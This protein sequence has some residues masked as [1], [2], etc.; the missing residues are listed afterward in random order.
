M[1]GLSWQHAR[2]FV[3]ST[4]ADLE[5]A[6]VQAHPFDSW[7]DRIRLWQLDAK[8]VA[9]AWLSPPAELDWHQRAEL[10]T[11]V[12]ERIIEEA[13]AW[14]EEAAR[15]A[16]EREGGRGPVSLTAWAMDAD[17]LLTT[18]LSREG[19]AADDAWALTHWY[20][21]LVD[22]PP[23]PGPRL[24][25]GYRLRHVRWPD[26]LAARVEVH[27]AA[28]APSKMTLEKYRRLAEMPH[29]SPDLDLVVEAPD[30][31]FAAFTLA[32]RDP[33]GGIGELEPVGT[34]P[35]HRRLGLARAANVA[36]LS[37][38]RAAG[39]IDALL[40]SRS[41]N[42]AAEALYASVGFRE[43]THSR[44]WRRSLE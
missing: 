34:H 32:W 44:P 36:A 4:P 21:R 26:D 6:R 9:H 29:Y 11:P 10:E 19:F 25:A 13:L 30:G 33:V 41:S 7:G 24:P 8:V 37:R 15:A 35:D 18:I 3:N 5:W 2:P 43:L 17:R 23:I 12:R 38:L 40:F 42:E 39:A 16:A 22:R 28:F 31:S 20:R 27:R 14:A 1:L